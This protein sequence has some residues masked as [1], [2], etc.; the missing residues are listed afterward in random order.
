MFEL[1]TLLLVQD[2][3]ANHG[4]NPRSVI[5]SAAG[6]EGDALAKIRGS[7]RLL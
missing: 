5:D 1:G 6:R 3:E 2:E 7:S 4:I